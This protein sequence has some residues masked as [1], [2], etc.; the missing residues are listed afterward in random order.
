MA[1]CLDPALVEIRL[2]VAATA[3]LAAGRGARRAPGPAPARSRRPPARAADAA[4]PRAQAPLARTWRREDRSPPPASPE[5]LAAPPAW[6][7]RAGSRSVRRPLVGPGFI[8]RRG[9]DPGG[10][11][12][13]PLARWVGGPRATALAGRGEDAILR[14]ALDSCTW[15]EHPAEVGFAAPPGL[16]PRAWVADPLAGGACTAGSEPIE[17]RAA[18]V[19]PVDGAASGRRRRG[20]AHGAL[21]TDARRRRRLSRNAPQSLPAAPAA[22][23]ETRGPRNPGGTAPAADR[24]RTTGSRESR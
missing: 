12:R 18:L 10:G 13:G 15:L 22:A 17:A 24:A 1:S 21:T 9:R 2:G 16:L 19:R 14:A 20:P 11:A 6:E 8:P 7:R 5:A 3:A 23:R 4:A